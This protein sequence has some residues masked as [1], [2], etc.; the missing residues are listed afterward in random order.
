MT[1]FYFL[2]DHLLPCSPPYQGEFF[3]YP[4]RP[5]SSILPHQSDFLLSIRPPVPLQSA[6]SRWFL[7]LSI[8][9][10]R[11]PV[12]CLIKVTFYFLFDCLSPW[13]PLYQGEIFTFYSPRLPPVVCLIKVNI[14]FPFFPPRP[15]PVFQF[16]MVPFYF[17]W[18][19]GLM[20][21]TYLRCLFILYKYLISL[22]WR[23]KHIRIPFCSI[24]ISYLYHLVL[25]MIRIPPL[26]SVLTV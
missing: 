19:K 23:K 15:S 4:S 10:A 2:S 5:S 9:P 20:R 6:L 17:V 1:L 22:F 13:S 11:P 12:F 25:Y 26:L 8:F 24:F 18:W 14:S 7:L 16:T 21:N 3:Y